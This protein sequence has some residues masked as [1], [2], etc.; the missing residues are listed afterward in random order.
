MSHVRLPD[1]VGVRVQSDEIFVNIV[2]QG[3]GQPS[4]GLSMECC[5]G[6]IRGFS[7]DIANKTLSQSVLKVQ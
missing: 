2:D 5:P 3:L 4:L 1:P 7:T 6:R